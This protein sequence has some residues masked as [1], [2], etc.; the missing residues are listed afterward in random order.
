MLLLLALA[1]DPTPKT[2]VIGQPDG[3]TDTQDTASAPLDPLA[4]A[5]EVS[6]DNLATTLDA[7]AG[8]G[9]RHTATDGDTLAADWLE[10]H[11]Q[12]LGYDVE[13]AA[14]DAD[15]EPAENV[16]ARLEGADP[17]VIWVYSAHYDS[18]SDQPETLAPGAD[19]NASGVAAVLE[20]A[21]ILRDQPLQHSVWFVLTA[22]EEQGS[23]GSAALAAQWSAEG[24]DIRGV[25]APDMIGYWPAGDDDA[26]DILGDEDSEALANDMA[27]AADA[28][29]VPYKLWIEH[30]YCYGDDHTSYQ[31]MDF[32]AISPMDCV[33]AHNVPSSGEDTPHYH[34]TTDTPDTVHLPFTARVAGVIVATLAGW[35]G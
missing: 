29:G 31:H 32:P 17:S 9:T 26:F 3:S 6:Q 8:L 19:D 2:G 12:D 27:A 14:F 23:L 11:L 20:A 28:L 33:E 35:A 1:C 21:R 18:T 24:L 5:G 22:A 4:L 10:A 15:G 16:I 7:L 13:R 25:I 30:R 34:R